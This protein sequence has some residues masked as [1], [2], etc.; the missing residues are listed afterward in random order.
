MKIYVPPGYEQADPA[1][2]PLL[3]LLH[4]SAADETQWIDVGVANAADCLIGSGEMQPTIIVALDGQRASAQA[5]GSPPA[6]ERFVADEV[7]PYL[8]N[9]FPNLGGRAVT[10]IGGISSGGGWALRIAADRPSL[11]SSVGG[12][13]PTVSL[14]PAQVRSLAAHDVRVWLDV[15]QDDSLRPRVLELDRAL[16]HHGSGAMVMSWKGGHD[17]HYWSHHVEDY[18]R[19]YAHGW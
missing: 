8:R 15:G 10:S 3:I 11:F 19:F 13:S 9:R 18:L 2:V 4:G 6:M 14:N 16:R 12:H 1:T 5:D 7:V 17:R